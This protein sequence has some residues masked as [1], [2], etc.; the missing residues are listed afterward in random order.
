MRL[1]NLL[2]PRGAVAAALVIGLFRRGG[3][4]PDICFFIVADSDYGWFSSRVTPD[5]RRPPIFLHA[6]NWPEILVL[7]SKPPIPPPDNFGSQQ[8][9]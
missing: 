3:A 7:V 2:D 4:R 5:L 8:N 6:T 1:R 9:F